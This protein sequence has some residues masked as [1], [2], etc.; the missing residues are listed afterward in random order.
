MYR[1]T[2]LLI[3]FVLGISCAHA[4]TFTYGIKGG[5]NLARLSFGQLTNDPVFDNT[6]SPSFHLGGFV[7]KAIGGQ[8][9]IRAE[10]LYST[11]GGRFERVSGDGYVRLHY[12]SLPVLVDFRVARKLAFEVGPELNY[13]I[14]TPQS[15][16]N[17]PVDVGIDAGLRYSFTTAFELGLRYNYGLASVA[18]L[19]LVSGNGGSTPVRNQALQV[20]LAYSLSRQ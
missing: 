1:S 12:L 13:L 15:L 10:V 4:Q 18:T 6:W 2:T 11:K 9:G 3:F 8:G 5:L 7:R 20:S 19:N 16:Y 14:S 17:N